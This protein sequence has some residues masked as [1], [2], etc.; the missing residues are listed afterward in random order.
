MTLKEP[1][2]AAYAGSLRYVSDS[3]PGIRRRRAGKGFRYIGLDGAAIRDEGT[4]RRIRTLA[5]PPAWQDVWICADPNGHLQATGRDEAGRKQYIYHPDWARV[6]EQTKFTRLLQFAQA[7]PALRAQVK[8]DLRTRE[9]TQN[10]VLALVVRL[11]ERTLIRIGNEEYQRQ[12]GTYGL[13]T[14]RDEHVEVRNGAVTFEFRGKSGKDHEIVLDD[15][16]LAR[17]V[18]ACQELPGQRLF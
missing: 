2:E 14:L 9:L 18:K 15:P 5:I 10:K 16:R 12:N 7:L 11:L 1:I 3:R 4:L 6:R 13:T 8:A 17:L